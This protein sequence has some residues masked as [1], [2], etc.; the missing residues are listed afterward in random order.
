MPK[1]VINAVKIISI[2]KI[3]LLFSANWTTP[4]S[5][6]K[7]IWINITTAKA[8]SN[9]WLTSIIN[10][11]LTRRPNNN[12]FYALTYFGIEKCNYIKFNPNLNVTNDKFC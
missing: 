8:I 4:L 5:E 12:L 3:V 6:I 10:A 1:K 9:I 7:I 11:N 2:I